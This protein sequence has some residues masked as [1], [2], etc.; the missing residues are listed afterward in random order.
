[1]KTLV[2]TSINPHSDL[3]YQKQCFDKWLELGYLVKTFNAR[4]ESELL[5]AKGVDASHIVEISEDETAANILGKDVPRILPLLNRAISFDVDAVLLANSDLYPAHSRQ[6]SPYLCSLSSAIALTRTEVVNIGASSYLGHSPYRGGLDVFFFTLEK[7]QKIFAGLQEVPVSQRM[8]FGVPGWDFYLAHVLLD[9]HHGMI[10]DGEVIFHRSHKTSYEA[11]G[12]FSGFAKEMIRSNAYNS[13][14]LEQLADE[15]AGLIN[16]HCERHRPQ[17]LLL[18]K[19]YYQ[20]TATN[21]EYQPVKRVLWIEREIFARLEEQG[22]S[23]DFQR[24]SLRIFIESQLSGLSWSAA[25]T[26]IIRKLDRWPALE[27]NLF[28]L[29]V[30]LVIRKGLEKFEVSYHYPEQSMHGSIVSHI[31][32]RTEGDEQL[33]Q[34]VE[35][36]STELCDHAVF[37]PN[38]L[39]YILLS[40]HS[41]NVAGLCFEILSV[42]K[43]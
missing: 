28:I 22:I 2:L 10:M 39:K 1:M 5:I 4:S 3:I 42:C 7:L 11:I 25:K 36:F 26:Y 34:V 6:L 13:V 23:L 8:A 14:L 32:D 35:L 40:S 29:L 33:A 41:A 37:N 9:Q 24:T 31:L 27:A 19:M 30:Q 12:E 20:N 18:K 15:F 16:K 17:S 43:R 38:L 21:H